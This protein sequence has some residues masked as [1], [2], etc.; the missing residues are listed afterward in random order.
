MTAVTRPVFQNTFARGSRWAGQAI[1]HAF[2]APNSVLKLGQEFRLDISQIPLATVAAASLLYLHGQET[3]K[4]G[5]QNRWAKLLAEAGLLYGIIS[6]TSGVLPLLGIGTIAYKAGRQP[7]A[8]SKVQEAVST[9][10]MM[11]MGY[12]GAM[13]GLGYSM[14]VMDSEARDLMEF[15]K[16]SKVRREFRPASQGGTAGG[17][18]DRLLKS[19]NAKEQELG[20]SLNRLGK[21]MDI[22]HQRIAEYLKFLE[23]N[24]G[25]D[26]KMAQMHRKKIDR[27]LFKVHERFSHPETQ[28]L[29]RR[30]MGEVSESLLKKGGDEAAKKSLIARKELLG[31]IGE[32]SMRVGSSQQGYVKFLR[33]A[34]PIFG[35]LIGAV[36]IGIPVAKAINGMIATAVP[37]LKKMR[38]EIP[39]KTMWL[40]EHSRRRGENAYVSSYEMAANPMMN[41]GLFDTFRTYQKNGQ[42]SA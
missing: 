17:L 9:T 33:A 30:E 20:K 38:P 26:P 19:P 15:L 31:R 41:P 12:L 11:G 18:V 23:N 36:L 8:L 1:H 2:K 35:A 14:S 29:L 40:P 37:G 7:D 27:V 10:S 16:D 6:Y 5:D 24:P 34:N 13:S 42:Y 28:A 3:A 32:L 25:A 22:S 39:S 4:G 21:Y